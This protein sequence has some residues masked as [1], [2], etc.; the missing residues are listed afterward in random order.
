M[1]VLKLNITDGAAAKKTV[2]TSDDKVVD[3]T[4][5]VVSFKQHSPTQWD[6]KPGTKPG[7]IIAKSDLGDKFEGTS[8]E[9][10]KLLR[11]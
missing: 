7:Y 5:E 10:S 9:F 4:T 6:I 2:L 8:R 1:A 3:N 11:A